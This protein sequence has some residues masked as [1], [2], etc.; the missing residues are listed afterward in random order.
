MPADFMNITNKVFVNR[1]HEPS[2]PFYKNIE[3][4]DIGGLAAIVGL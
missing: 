4:K 2:A 3:I 1:G